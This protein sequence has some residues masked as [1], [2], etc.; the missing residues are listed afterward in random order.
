MGIGWGDVITALGLAAVIEGALYALYP[1]PARDTWRR[2]AEMDDAAL[3]II[4]IAAAVFGVFL[5]WM[6]RG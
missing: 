5:V 1:G 6:V 3:R 4:G 2:M